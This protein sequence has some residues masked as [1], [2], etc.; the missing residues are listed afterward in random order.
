MSGNQILN[1]LS[2]TGTIF[3]YLMLVLIFIMLIQVVRSLLLFANALV[4][5]LAPL[6][7]TNQRIENINEFLSKLLSKLEKRKKQAHH[8]LQLLSFI[9]TL[10]HLFKKKNKKK[11]YQ[12]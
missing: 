9:H 3:F 2:H 4:K 7:K 8:T 11:A 12:H 5:T 1:F 10:T 6:E